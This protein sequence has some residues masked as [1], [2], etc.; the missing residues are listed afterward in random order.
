MPCKACASSGLLHRAQIQKNKPRVVKAFAGFSAP[1]PHPAGP[2]PGTENELEECCYL[3]GNWRILQ[4]V[5][6]HR[7]STDDVVTAWAG[8]RAAGALRV[9]AGERLRTAD[10]GCGLGSVLLMTAWLFPGALCVGA[11]AQAARFVLA[12]R[13]LA[14]NLGAGQRRAAVVQGDLREASTLDSLRSAAAMLAGEEG[15]AAS[16]G[17]FHL[18]TGTPPYFAVADGGTPSHEESAR[19]LFEYRGGVE[20]YCAAAAALLAPGGVFAVCQTSRELVR[21]Y[22][23]AKAAG[24]RPLARLDTLPVTGKPPLFFVL[25][26]C[27]EGATTC[28]LT[29]AAFALP[30]EGVEA[31][32]SSGSGGGGGG[33]GG[34]GSSGCDSGDLSQ[35]QQPLPPLP[36]QDM[37]EAP[38]AAW[39]GA[40]LESSAAAVQQAASAPAAKQ[41]ARGFHVEHCGLSLEGEAAVVLQVR[42]DRGE[43]T[44][45][46]KR[47]LWELGKPS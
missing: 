8:W 3:T 21:T 22:A 6:S 11:E 20:A 25:V 9:G 37:Q 39:L 14:L 10:I 13:S 24:L 31:S 12:Q 30:T 28:S 23:A 27:L 26:C 17:G 38:Y 16:S 33:G 34:G 40:T 7:Y 2:L 43:R 5:D 4:R 47:L 29:P 46:Y 15:G 45:E 41:S 18:V 42:G 19:C 44:R 36:Y 32:G 35:R 1:G